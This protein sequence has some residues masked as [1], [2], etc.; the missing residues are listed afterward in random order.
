MFGYPMNLKT[1]ISDEF[2]IKPVHLRRY[3]L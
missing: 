3:L 2:A 1:M